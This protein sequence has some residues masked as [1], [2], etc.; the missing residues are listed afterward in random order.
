MPKWP[1]PNGE[2]TDVTAATRPTPS[3]EQGGGEIALA[4]EPGQSALAAQVARAR[5]LLAV[6]E[7]QSYTAAAQFVG[8]G[9]AIPLR[10][11]WRGL[12]ATAWLQWCRNMVA[13]TGSAMARRSSDAS[14]RSRPGTRARTG[15]HGHLVAE[16]VAERAAPG[17]RWPARYQH[18]YDWPRLA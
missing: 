17:R 16:Y 9:S 1:L 14:W 5:A 18:L 4:A 6:A 13:V 2:V 12:T 8:R 10:A 11:K 3:V 15:W 7:G